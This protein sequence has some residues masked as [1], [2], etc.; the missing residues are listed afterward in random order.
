MRVAILG[1]GSLVGMTDDH[2]KDLKGHIDGEWVREG[3][4]L[5]IEFARISGGRRHGALTLVIDRTHGEPNPVWY[6]ASKRKDPRD[7]ACDLRVREGTTTENIGLICVRRGVDRPGRDGD[8]ATT[9]AIAQWARE[10][11]IDAVTWT[12]LRSNFTEKSKKKVPFSV[13][14][15]LDHLQNLPPEGRAAAIE[16]IERLVPAAVVTPLRTALRATAWWQSWLPAT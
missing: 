10:R 8:G 2:L 4:S 5:P 12:D 3:P 6:I 14:D 1:W 9:D 16:Y 7:A 13:P 15:G 11:D